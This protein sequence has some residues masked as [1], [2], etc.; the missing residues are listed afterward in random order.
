[1]NMNERLEE[2]FDELMADHLDGGLPQ[3]AAQIHLDRLVSLLRDTP[4]L[5]AR[6]VAQAEM[7]GLLDAHFAN[8]SE[9]AT[10]AALI[11]RTM[12][13]LPE[14]PNADH[15]STKIMSAIA[16]K[17]LGIAAASRSRRWLRW[18]LPAAAVIIV[19][20]IFGWRYL[21][22]NGPAMASI[23]ML[24]SSGEVYILSNMTYE[25]QRRRASTNDEPLYSIDGVELGKSGSAGITYFDGTT[26]TFEGDGSTLWLS[27]LKRSRGSQG[28]RNRN[29]SLGKQLAFEYNSEGGKLTII[30][31]KQPPDAPMH[32]Y[33]EDT[34]VEI[35]GTKLIVEVQKTGTLISV[36]EGRV[37]VT[38]LSDQKSIFLNAHEA[39]GPAL[40]VVPFNGD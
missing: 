15:T 1:M 5:R 38:R 2:Q 17:P 34:D 21:A 13:S 40:E 11:E 31:S 36:I 10:V 4:S 32:I 26:A 16:P 39:C 20:A 23:A 7:A 18:G 33:T 6:F 12:V 27:F 8:T 37:K 35:V 3:S 30:A 14:R 19:A 24:H 9:G 25:T 22:R 29:A 28:V